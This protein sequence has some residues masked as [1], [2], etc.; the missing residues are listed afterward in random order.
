[1]APN[2]RNTEV[3]FANLIVD[4]T[5]DLAEAKSKLFLE[6]KLQNANLIVYATDKP[7]ETNVD[8]VTILGNKELIIP[9]ISE[10]DVS[11]EDGDD[12]V[13]DSNIDDYRKLNVQSLKSIAIS[14]GLSTDPSKL[15]KKEL[16]HLLA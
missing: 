6:T 16:L 13:V 15:K 10:N 3:G 14:K 2:P 11:N 5:L 8:D 12:L 4:A 7:I 9:E 1:M